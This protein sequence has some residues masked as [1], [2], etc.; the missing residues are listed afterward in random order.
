MLIGTKQDEVSVKLGLQGGVARLKENT[1]AILDYESGKPERV[2]VL[3]GEE[4]S[5]VTIEAGNN[6]LISLN[7]GQ[8]G[9]ISRQTNE[10]EQLPVDGSARQ[11]LPTPVRSGLSVSK[12][13]V[14]VAQLLQSEPLLRCCLSIQGASAQNVCHNSWIA[15]RLTSDYH[16]TKFPEITEKLWPQSRSNAE[17][18]A[19]NSRLLDTSG[20]TR[21][22]PPLSSASLLT[23]AEGK[24][25]LKRLSLPE[26]PWSK[27]AGSGI[28]RSGSN[29]QINMITDRH[30]RLVEGAV[31]ISA[32]K[33][34]FI[35]TAQASITCK[36]GASVLLSAS[37]NITRI[38][39]L[40]DRFA[41]DVTVQTEYKSYAL[42]PGSE[43]SIVK[44]LSRDAAL[45]LV[46]AE[47]MARRR[48][49][50]VHAS[51]DTQLFAN[52]F[53]IIDALQR[54]PLLADLSR[55][56]DPTEKRLFV[57]LMKTAAAL[58]LSTDGTHGAFSRGD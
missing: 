46:I 28:L 52:D 38:Y 14:S 19:T 16:K 44:G 29:L 54:S 50:L 1:I 53:S 58:S 3:S 4:P 36:T 23:D 13:S 45:R 25:S 31:L 48:M 5:S 39:D 10:K 21:E 15:Q 35:D 33:A 9:I 42:T 7:S 32:R 43:M 34:I 41:G 37:N 20:K 57:N 18:P 49:Q 40:N 2:T 6:E 56:A 26:Q 27:G 22:V 30:Y 17:E 47:K 24:N 55:C 8:E 12:N 11:A 51:N